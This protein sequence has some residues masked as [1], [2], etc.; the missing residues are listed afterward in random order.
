MTVIV[1]DKACVEFFKKTQFRHSKNTKL[2]KCM[3]LNL[4]YKTAFS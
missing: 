3:F 2:S 4:K 1:T